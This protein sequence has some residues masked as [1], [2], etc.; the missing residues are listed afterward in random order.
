MGFCTDL[1]I[2]NQEVSGGGVLQ[3]VQIVVKGR[4]ALLQTFAFPNFTDDLEGFAGRVAG[5]TREDLPVVEHT[6]REGLAT[7]VAA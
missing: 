5:V 6:L 7:S 1:V 3:F 2:Y 4:Y